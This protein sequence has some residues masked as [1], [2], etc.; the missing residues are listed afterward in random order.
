MIAGKTILVT[1]ATSGIGQA[2]AR[3]FNSCGA[4]VV[5]VAR[6]EDKLKDMV[7]EFNGKGYIY[8]ADLGALE[9]VEKIFAFCKEKGLKL[10]GVVH[11]AG[12]TANLPLRVND[13]QCMEELM[14]INFESLVL[15]CKFASSKRYTN[16]GASIVAMSSTASFCGDRG[17]SL[18]SASKGA[19][20]TFVKAAAKELVTRRIRVNAIAPTMVNT[21]MCAETFRDLPER[22]V[23][24]ERELPLGIIEPEY[25][26]YLAEYLISD[27]AK[28]ITG[29][30]ITMGSGLI[31]Q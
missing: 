19:V 7:A 27:K 1:G 3:H 12:I 31:V 18:Y 26:A 25:I 23:S 11:C 9:N 14:R 10:D 2:T 16:D 24:L 30:I 15:I 17:L 21:N 8:P 5:M 28:Y 6:S 22:R 13:I 29:S 20:N 4:A